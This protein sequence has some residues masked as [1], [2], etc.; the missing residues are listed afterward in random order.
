MMLLIK[1]YYTEKTYVATFTNIYMRNAST[2]WNKSL[3]YSE[4][5]T[6][7]ELI[8]SAEH[9]IHNKDGIHLRFGHN[10]VW[11]GHKYKFTVIGWRIDKVGIYENIVRIEEL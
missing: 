8:F 9:L 7:E 11:F 10:C 5:E 6:G 1:S 4:T 3:I 2:F